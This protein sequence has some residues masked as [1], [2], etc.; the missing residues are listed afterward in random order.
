[1]K[2]FWPML[3]VSAVALATQRGVEQGPQ[4][5]APSKQSVKEE[6]CWPDIAE[7]KNRNPGK[8]KPIR[9]P[10]ELLS[11]RVSHTPLRLKLCISSEGKVER[12]I[13]T[14]SSGNKEVDA[15]YRSA[16]SARTYQPV[17]HDLVAVSSVLRV[18]V[19]LYIK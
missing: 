17:K 3:L 8:H 12:A 18:S 7:V 16:L 1:M 10:E 14:E 19:N 4:R 11:E 13:V 15:F 9:L 5:S 6:S 2:C